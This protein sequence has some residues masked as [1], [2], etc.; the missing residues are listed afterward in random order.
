M[1]VIEGKSIYSSSDIDKYKYKDKDNQE[2]EIKIVSK[3]IVELCED[4]I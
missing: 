3:E 1:K 2:H 4:D